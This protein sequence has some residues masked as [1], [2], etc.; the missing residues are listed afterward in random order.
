MPA[1]EPHLYA[2]VFAQDE[3]GFNFG[4][5]VTE[6]GQARVLYSARTP[7]REFRIS[8]DLPNP[9]R[10]LV[11]EKLVPLISHQAMHPI[12][13]T[14]FTQRSST[15]P[16]VA[17]I[18]PWIEDSR[19]RILAGH[20]PRIF[21]LAECW[22]IPPYVEDPV[23]W[24]AAA[25][26]V[27][28][29][30]DKERF[31]LVGTWQTRP[32]WRRP[33]EMKVVAELDDFLAE[34]DRVEKELMAREQRLRHE[35]AGARELG[36]KGIR[37]LLTAKARDLVLIVASMLEALGFQVEDMDEVWPEGDKRDDLRV[38]DAGDPDWVGLVEVR[39]YTGGG[40]VR[41]FQRISRFQKPF[42]KD[43]N[44]LPSRSWYMVNQFFTVDP[45]IRDRLLGSNPDEVEEFAHDDGLAI[46]S[47]TLFRL[48][49][50]VSAGDLQKDQAMRILKGQTGILTYPV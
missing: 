29:Q 1:I 6:G 50:D 40:A 26:Q 11:I 47:R 36:D 14:Q 2:L 18:V 37:S 8:Q 25:L 28:N 34:R 23:P 38:R 15:G 32:A 46:D 41:D 19:G 43:E 35:L 24:L 13:D 9:L 3:T 33:E 39:G 12:V 27:W 30:R 31:P 45:D 17:P 4:E 20:F 16:T 5:I 10:R 44:R 22:C 21:D 42:L 7:A 49:R 48:H